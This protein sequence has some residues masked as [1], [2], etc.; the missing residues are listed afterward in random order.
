MAGSLTGGAYFIFK[1]GT[2]LLVGC[3]TDHPRTI[4]FDTV[5]G[6]MIPMADVSSVIVPANVLDCVSELQDTVTY[7]PDTAQTP[8][9]VDASECLVWT[10]MDV[11]NAS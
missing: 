2:D 1:A 11:T 4:Q 5:N 10:R 6:A 8:I 3:A 7:R 9:D